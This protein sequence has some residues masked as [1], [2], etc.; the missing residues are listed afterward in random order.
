MNTKAIHTVHY[1]NLCTDIHSIRLVVYKYSRRVIK[2]MPTA[3]TAAVVATIVEIKP[4]VARATTAATTA[5]AIPVVAISVV[6]G[7]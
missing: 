3:R 5:V 2:R 6:E 1:M 7:L 4:V